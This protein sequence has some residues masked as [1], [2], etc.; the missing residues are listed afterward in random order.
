MTGT[1]PMAGHAEMN[2]A[3]RRSTAGSS[4]RWSERAHAQRQLFF[5]PWRR[6]WN[7][8]FLADCG[9]ALSV[10]ACAFAAN[11]VSRRCYWCLFIDARWVLSGQ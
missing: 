9:A 1:D 11:T 5:S 4:G 10:K 3:T 7:D 6:W 8:A 2:L